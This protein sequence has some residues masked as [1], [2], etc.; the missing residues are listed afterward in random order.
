MNELFESAGSVFDFNRE[1]KKVICDVIRSCEE[2]S[3]I[4]PKNIAVSYTP[5]KTKGKYGLQAKIYPLRFE[6]GS[7]EK[8]V[9]G[10]LF[11]LD[12]IFFDNEPVYYIIAFCVPRFLNLA[13]SEKL[14]T[15]VHELFH[16]SPKFNGDIRRLSLGAKAAHGSSKDIFDRFVAKIVK[17]YLY[18]AERA[19]LPKFLYFDYKKLA[20]HYSEIKFE[21]LKIPRIIME[22]SEQIYQP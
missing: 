2:F 20:Q 4:D 8:T 9:D 21:K 3:H 6:G 1:Y 14:E 16:I 12:E 15:I 17:R 7:I 22:K 11:R 19:L 13:I 5:S 18:S 10:H